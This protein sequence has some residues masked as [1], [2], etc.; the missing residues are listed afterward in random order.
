MLN[1]SDIGLLFASMQA[2]YGHSWAHKADAV[3]IWLRALG[4]FNRDDLT[5]ALSEV[6]SEYPDFPPTLGQFEKLL[7]GPNKLPER[8]NTYLPAP[9]MDRRRIIA[10][11]VMMKVMVS[12]GGVSKV[13]L[14]NMVGLKNALADEWGE[15]VTQE[16][17]RDLCR[18][19]M[20]LVKDDDG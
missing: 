5:K 1:T 20:A 16:N 19:L 4:G 9:K 2:I 17:V 10:N 7:S 6:A 3:P 12:S 8:P 15:D 18:Q 14:R 11:R 13:T